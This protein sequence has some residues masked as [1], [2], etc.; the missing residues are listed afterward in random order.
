MRFT[1]WEGGLGSISKMPP[2]LA[3]EV[4]LHTCQWDALR[5]VEVSS[6]ASVEVSGFASDS[7]LWQQV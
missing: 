3:R 5:S 7:R 2:T 1:H 4:S 6:V